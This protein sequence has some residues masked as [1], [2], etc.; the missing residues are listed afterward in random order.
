MHGYRA[1]NLFQNDERASKSLIDAQEGKV[2][3]SPLIN[4][5]Q[6]QIN[7]YFLANDLPRHPLIQDGYLSIGCENCTVKTSNNSNPRS[8]RW[9]GT[10]KLNVEFI[11]QKIQLKK[12]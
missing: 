8:G 9:S 1:E 2:I 4:W 12:R 7:E 3:I 6:K 11:S 5:S 10:E